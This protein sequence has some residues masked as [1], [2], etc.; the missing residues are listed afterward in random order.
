MANAGEGANP[1]G[2]NLEDL[3][4]DTM[5]WMAERPRRVMAGMHLLDDDQLP[6]E[7]HAARRKGQ[8]AGILELLDVDGLVEALRD[9]H[10]QAFW[11]YCKGGGGNAFYPSRVGHVMSVLRGR[12]LF[13]ELCEKCLSADILPLAIYETTDFRITRDHPEW[14]QKPVEMLRGERDDLPEGHA[15]AW[16]EPYGDLLIEQARE[17]LEGY[18][19]K[20]FYV[21]AIAGHSHGDEYLSPSAWR[22]FHRDFG[23]EYPGKSALSHEDD[24]RY[25]RWRLQ[26][27]HEYLE[28]VRNAVKDVRPDVAFTY[29][30]C[31]FADLCDFVSCD[32]FTLKAGNLKLEQLLRRNAALSRP[33]SGEALLDGMSSRAQEAKGLDGYRAECWTARSL[34]VA[35]C[36]SF[37]MRLDGSVPQPQLDLL[38]EAM[39][40]QVRFEPWLSD[41]EPVRCIGILDSHDTRK[42][43]P[44]GS[45]PSDAHARE[46]EGWM[47]TICASGY[48]WEFLDEQLLTDE[49]LA[50]LRTLVLPNVSCISDAQ[51]KVIRNFVQAG[52]SLIM[53]GETSLFD[54]NG[55]RREQPALAGLAG[56]RFIEEARPERSFLTLPTDGGAP[57]SFAMEDGICAVEALEDARALGGVLVTLKPPELDAAPVL[58]DSD[59]PGMTLR[60]FGRG[61]VLYVAGTPGAGFARTGRH[62][63]K[64]FMRKVLETAV[65]EPLVR[66]QGPETV[67]VYS[68]RQCGQNR[69]VVNLVNHAGTTTRT[70]RGAPCE[71]VD[72]M[73]PVPEATVWVDDSVFGKFRSACL[74]PSGN[75]IE[76]QREGQWVRATT[77]G[78]DVHAMVVFNG[79]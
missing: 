48:L 68:H 63:A 79:G 4:T 49:H 50:G 45:G 64:I 36:G 29:N 66:L 61:Q 54:E 65:A 17:V 71:D 58:V 46:N 13:G 35:T 62:R 27:V 21:D 73:P 75:E 78:F 69:L 1:P 32:I 41:P 76:L 43:H 72:R 20:A 11:I 34:G 12:D 19:V 59:L 9:A 8:V 5:R 42:F 60:S 22:R 6:D 77:P 57:Q 23:F 18:P 44:P 67:S 52:G 38:A 28:R 33:H 51:A 24:V 15:C 25:I 3:M 2:R 16:S 70:V 39:G 14:R 26:C 31:G 56:I 7:Y 55:R 37:M 30:Y 74:A 53:T 40:E 47:R 10:V